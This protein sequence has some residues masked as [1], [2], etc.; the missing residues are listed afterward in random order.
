MWVGLASDKWNRDDGR[1]KID[2]VILNFGSVDSLGW[3]SVC[4]GWGR[5]VSWTL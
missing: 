1:K 4:W 2:T 3:M 5:G